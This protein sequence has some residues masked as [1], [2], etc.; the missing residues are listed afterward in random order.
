MKNQAEKADGISKG[1]AKASELFASCQKRSSHP[2]SHRRQTISALRR[3]FSKGKSQIVIVSTLAGG[4]ADYL[5]IS[6]TKITPIVAL[7]LLTFLE[8][9]IKAYCAGKKSC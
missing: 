6:A 9:G 3:S 7:S 5:G 4:I 2:P 8:V 1:F